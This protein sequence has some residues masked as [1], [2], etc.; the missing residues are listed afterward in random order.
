MQQCWKT[1]PSERPSFYSLKE[2]MSNMKKHHVSIWIYFSMYKFK[3]SKL[4]K[5]LLNLN[6]F[7]TSKIIDNSRR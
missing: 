6:C 4:K 3:T 2:T 7:L 1:T 5:R